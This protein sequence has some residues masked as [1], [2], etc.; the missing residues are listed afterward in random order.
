MYR[1]LRSIGTSFAM[2][3]GWERGSDSA[4]PC[5]PSQA[6][7]MRLVV[8]GFPRFDVRALWVTGMANRLRHSRIAAAFSGRIVNCI[9]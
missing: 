1:G 8:H 7:N 3:N 9:R 4:L 5:D 6:C 2:R